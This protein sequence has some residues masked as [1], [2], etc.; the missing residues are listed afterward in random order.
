MGCKD[1]ASSVVNDSVLYNSVKIL[2]DYVFS[3][4]LT[5]DLFVD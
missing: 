2:S 4:K 1:Y 5:F 3:I